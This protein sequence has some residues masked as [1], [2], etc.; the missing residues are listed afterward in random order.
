MNFMIDGDS[1]INIFELKHSLE[2]ATK[3]KNKEDLSPR[4]MIACALSSAVGSQKIGLNLKFQLICQ[5]SFSNYFHN[6]KTSAE[7]IGNLNAAS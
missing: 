1:K 7:K 4:P 6:G 3:L 5:E 2:V